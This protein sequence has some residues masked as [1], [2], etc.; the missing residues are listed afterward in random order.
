[1]SAG[2]FD[3]PIFDGTYFKLKIANNSKIQA[4]CILCN[5]ENDVIFYNYNIR[6]SYLLLYVTY[7]LFLY[8][9][10]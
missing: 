4:V 2:A 1:M 7:L 10:L 6:T 8:C 5:N 3:Q 9:D